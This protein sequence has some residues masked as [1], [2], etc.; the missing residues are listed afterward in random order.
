MGTIEALLKEKPE[1]SSRNRRRARSE[2][3]L[4]KKHELDIVDNGQPDG[5]T[6]GKQFAG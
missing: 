3:E 5:R 6:G 2:D 4:K 1:S